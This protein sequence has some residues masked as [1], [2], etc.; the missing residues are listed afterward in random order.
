MESGPMPAPLALDHERVWPPILGPSSTPS[1]RINARLLALGGREVARSADA[2][3]RVP[4]LAPSGD[5]YPTGPISMVRPCVAGELL[6][7]RIQLINDGVGT[8]A[9]R[10][11]ELLAER[12]RVFDE[13]PQPVQKQ[14][15]GDVGLV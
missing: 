3:V 6:T 1:R 5:A 8:P 11:C 15:V 14:A 9:G 10:D 4:W 7:E 2:G 12:L 13:V